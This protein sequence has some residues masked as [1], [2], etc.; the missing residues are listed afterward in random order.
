MTVSDFGITITTTSAVIIEVCDAI[1]KHLGPKYLH[2]PHTE[3]EMYEN[4]SDF[5][6]EFGMMQ[7]FG[8]RWHPYSDCFN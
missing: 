4:F 8:N 1:C 3:Q 2:L 5:E 6:T 7:A